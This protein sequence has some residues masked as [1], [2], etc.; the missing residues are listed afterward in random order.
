[1]V[2]EQLNSTPAITPDHPFIQCL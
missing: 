2:A 1:M